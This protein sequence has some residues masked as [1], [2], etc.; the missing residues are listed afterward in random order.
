MANSNIS[1]YGEKALIEK[2]IKPLFNPNNDL[3][4]IGDDCAMIEDKA[5]EITLL[6]T[7]RVPADLISFKLGLI[8]Y[9]GLGNYL[10]QLNISDIVAFGGKP[11]GLL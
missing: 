11:V 2:F 3:F 7:D 1:E 8:D 10:A 6:S 9:F 5:D 4:G